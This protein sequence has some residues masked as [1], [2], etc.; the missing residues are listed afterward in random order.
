MRVGVCTGAIDA[1]VAIS[2]D[3]DLAMPISV[4]RT[5]V[6][7][8]LVN[9]PSGLMPTRLMPGRLTRHVPRSES[10]LFG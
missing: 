2:N 10:C 4:N 5:R 6:P 8:G 9:S 7:V 1:A 3:S